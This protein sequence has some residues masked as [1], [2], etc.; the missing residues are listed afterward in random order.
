MLDAPVL[1]AV[2]GYLVET[3]K[4]VGEGSAETIRHS[5]ALRSVYLGRHATDRIG[6]GSPIL[7][8]APPP[9]APATPS[10]CPDVEPPA[11]GR[12]PGHLGSRRSDRPPRPADAR[13]GKAG[14]GRGARR[15]PL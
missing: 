5:D 11:G 9:P 8:F 3:G 13:A 1:L 6:E 14:R 12:D 2:H 4:I 10:Q 15:Q 7:A